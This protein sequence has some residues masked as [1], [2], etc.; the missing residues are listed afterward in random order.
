MKIEASQVQSYQKLAFDAKLSKLKPSF[1][2]DIPD[3]FISET[4]ENAGDG[5]HIMEWILGLASSAGAGLAFFR[6]RK[7][8]IAKQIAENEKEVIKKAKSEAEDVLSK[9]K[10]EN[11]ALDRQLTEIRD[12]IIPP[13]KTEKPNIKVQANKTSSTRNTETTN[14]SVLSEK[15]KEHWDRTIKEVEEEFAEHK[16]Q[17]DEIEKQMYANKEIIEYRATSSKR[18]LLA[19]AKGFGRILGYQTQKNFFNEKFLKPIRTN[20]ELPNMILMYGPKVT[21][22]TLF[23]KAVAHE[24]GANYLQLELTLSK[25]EDLQ[26]LKN[27]AQKAKE[28]YQKTGK[29]SVIHIDE[30][31][32]I[33]FTDEYAEIL[34]KLSKDYHATLFATTNHPKQLNPQLLNANKSEKIYMPTATKEDIAEIFKYVLKDFSEP[35]VDYNQL[36]QMAIDKANG[37]AYSNANIYNLADKIVEQH[38]GNMMNKK[39]D[40][41]ISSD[42]K[43]VSAKEILKAISENLKPDISQ[44]ILKEYKNIF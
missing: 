37:A 32:G 30:I 13:V 40:H 35:N 1:K 20:S 38:Y 8:R 23:A 28:L 25:Q 34:N 11:E 31:D 12:Q 36:A 44:E 16:K 6:N 7:A 2:A 26:N 33:V 24:G 5:N 15:D 22:K 19:Q 4:A 21:G 9:L 41:K 39:I 17:L 14:T 43:P 27:A 18:A 29:S 42:L 3:E 10:A